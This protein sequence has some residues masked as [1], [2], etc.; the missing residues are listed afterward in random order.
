MD[1][2]SNCFSAHIETVRSGNPSLSDNSL[3]VYDA[4]DPHIAP[5]LPQV[6]TIACPRI[7]A[8]ATSSVGW[9][10]SVGQKNLH[11]ILIPRFG[12]KRYS[13]IERDDVLQMVFD[14]VPDR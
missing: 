9:H 12:A 7:Y 14:L 5:K 10:R 13:E 11:R 2:Q 8:A 3:L 6:S 4:I 1:G